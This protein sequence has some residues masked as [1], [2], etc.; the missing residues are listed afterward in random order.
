MSEKNQEEKWESIEGTCICICS[1]FLEKCKGVEPYS[2]D[3][4]ICPLCE[5]TYCFK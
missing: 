4:W 1:T 5:S 2:E 3:Y